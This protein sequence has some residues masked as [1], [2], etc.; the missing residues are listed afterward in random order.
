FPAHPPIDIVGAGDSFLAGFSVAYGCGVK[1]YHALRF[2]SLVSNVTI[3]KVG[4]TG[5]ATPV[6]LRCAL[7]KGM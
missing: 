7:E 2:G 6:E 4:T 3:H 5:T 1:P